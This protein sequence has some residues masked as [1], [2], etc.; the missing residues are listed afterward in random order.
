MTTMKMRNY[1]LGR[2]LVDPYE[3]TLFNDCYPDALRST[4]VSDFKSNRLN[5]HQTLD[6][7]QR[8]F[9]SHEYPRDFVWTKG[10]LRADGNVYGVQRPDGNYDYELRYNPSPDVILW[11]E[12]MD[13]NYVFRLLREGIVAGRDILSEKEPLLAT[14]IPALYVEIVEARRI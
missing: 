10:E 13:R 4:S 3:Q 8:A 2:L 6:L 11:V 7:P 14:E 1:G 5:G 12:E 9:P